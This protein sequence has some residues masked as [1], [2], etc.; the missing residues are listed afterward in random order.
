MK[1][2][3]LMVKI[4]LFLGNPMPLIRRK[5]SNNDVISFPTPD[6]IQG[7]LSFF[8]YYLVFGG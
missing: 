3:I 7:V 1:L 5:Y 6:S 8:L 4:K 2:D